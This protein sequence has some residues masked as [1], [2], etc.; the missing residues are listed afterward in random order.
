MA[1]VKRFKTK[2][3][4]VFFIE[5]TSA[6][7]KPERI[8]YIRYFK[9][10]KAVEEKAGR[11]F[12][13]NMTPSQAARIRAARIEGKELSNQ[14]KRDAERAERAAEEGRWTIDRLA[15]EYFNSRP[16][17]K[18]KDTDRRRYEKHLKK[19]FGPKEPCEIQPLEVD[20][21]RLKLLKTRSPQTVKHVLNLLTW[22]TNFGFKKN[23]SPR[24][25]FNIVKP[26][27][28]NQKTE[29]LAPDEVKRLLAALKDHG[30]I[31]IE[32]LVKMALFTGMRR[33]ELFKLQWDHVDFLNGFIKIV[34]PKGGKTQK[35]PMSDEARAILENHPRTAGTPFVFPGRGGQQRASVSQ[36]LRKIR[37]KAGLPKD[38]RPLHGLRHHFASKLASSGAVDLYMIQRLLTHKDPRMTQ[39]YSHLHDGALKSAANLAGKILSGTGEKTEPA[40]AETQKVVNLEDHRE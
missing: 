29:F 1:C 37:Q 35:I 16:D 20:R 26:E 10:G 8:F 24:L 31:Q 9:G 27:V 30:D 21:M 4:G 18:G 12:Q 13:D 36:T 3:P 22:I 40:E 39:R 15:A 32:N 28:D 11:Q 33:G 2:Y 6:G 7:G 23:L 38:F 17:N 14:D 34:S 25:N 5:G 19:L